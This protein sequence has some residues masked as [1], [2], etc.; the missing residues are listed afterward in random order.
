M[1][2]RSRE[3]NVFSMSA[4]DLFA[5][6]LGAFILMAVVL[7]PYFL[8][9]DPDVVQKQLAE[10]RAK[11]RAAE[12]RLQEFLDAPKMT[13]PHLDVVI[14]LDTSGSMGAA[15]DGL[16][17]DIDEFA[18]LMFELAPSL[19][20]GIIDY[21]D[22]CD[23]T[24]AVREFPLRLMSSAGLSS[25]LSFTGSLRAKSPSCND[26]FE[27][28]LAMALDTGIASS[29]RRESEARIIVIITDAPAYPDKQASALSAA[30][31]FAGRGPRHRVSTVMTRS[32][33]ETEEY[34]R[35]LADAG[36]GKFTRGGRSFVV[37]M[38]FALA[39]L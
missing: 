24:T 22:R 6:A 3:V 12:Q 8:R 15:V 38:L 30:R 21:E 18:Q 19:G 13:F 39:G 10:A 25:L 14:A 37:M 26:D 35:S 1:R 11:Q 34:L 29:W 36:N 27:E 32:S 28:A 17:Q 33:P 7:M 16:R 31:A 9:V 20:I 23:M 2:S 4:L 5:S